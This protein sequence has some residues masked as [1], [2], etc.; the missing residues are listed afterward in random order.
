MNEVIHSFSIFKPLQQRGKATGLIV[1]G[2]H[3]LVNHRQSRSTKFGKYSCLSHPVLKQ[4][5]DVRL[6]PIS[7]ERL[8]TNARMRLSCVEM[9]CH[10]AIFGLLIKANVCTKQY[11]QANKQKLG[12]PEYSKA[13]KGTHILMIYQYFRLC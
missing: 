9:G 7:P 11:E 4:R 13:S 5:Q 8:C 1:Q 12:D 3:D 2:E 10:T 6:R